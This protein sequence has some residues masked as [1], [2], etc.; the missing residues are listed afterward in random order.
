M[1]GGEYWECDQ[2][3]SIKMPVF[4]FSPRNR[5]FWGLTNAQ[6][7]NVTP[8]WAVRLKYFYT[9]IIIIVPDNEKTGEF[10]Y[11]KSIRRSNDDILFDLKYVQ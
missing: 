3:Q 2:I 11:W 1:H 5:R 7:M 4:V 9:D 8:Y 10:L 6:W